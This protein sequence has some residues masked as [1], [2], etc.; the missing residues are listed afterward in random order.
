MSKKGQRSKRMKLGIS[1][2]GNTRN[3]NE[4]NLCGDEIGEI[5]EKARSYQL[6]N[7]V[8]LNSNKEARPREERGRQVGG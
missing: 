5:A 2:A 7:L 4:D 6:F 8:Y 1:E 3:A